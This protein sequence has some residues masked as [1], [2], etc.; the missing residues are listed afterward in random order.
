M[1]KVYCIMHWQKCK[2]LSYFPLSC[3]FHQSLQGFQ[4]WKEC[5]VLQV[6]QNSFIKVLLASFM[7]L[8]YI[9][10]PYNN[11][12]CIQKILME[13]SV[14]YDVFG[15]HTNMLV[16]SIFRKSFV[17]LKRVVEFLKTWVFTT[18]QSF[19]IYIMPL[20]LCE[21]NSHSIL[22]KASSSTT[23]REGR[24]Q[25]LYIYSQCLLQERNGGTY[26]FSIYACQKFIIEGVIL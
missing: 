24:T 12:P 7:Q 13:A 26:S 23:L 10:R 14:M 20:R 8:L 3:L 22:S 6:V 9:S 16:M 18:M 25:I 15:W 21:A 17:N 19:I 1:T 2:E 11:C 5:L 4:N